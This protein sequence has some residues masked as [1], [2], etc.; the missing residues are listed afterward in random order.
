M[1]IWATSMFFSPHP[2]PNRIFFP[3]RVQLLE[4]VLEEDWK[5]PRF[6]SQI[7][8]LQFSTQLIAGT[9]FYWNHQ[10]LWLSALLLFFWV[11]EASH[12]YIYMYIYIDI[13]LIHI[14]PS[15]LKTFEC[16]TPGIYT[17]LYHTYRWFNLL[18]SEAVD[19]AISGTQ[20]W[21]FGGFVYKSPKGHENPLIWDNH[22]K[23]LQVWAFFGGEQIWCPKIDD[24]NVRENIQMELWDD[25][26][27]EMKKDTWNSKANH[28]LMDGNG[29][30]QAFFHGKRFGEPSSNW[31]VVILMTVDVSGSRCI[32]THE[33]PTCFC[34]RCEP[35]ENFSVKLPFSW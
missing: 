6:A 10:I 33:I 19:L 27:P 7:L 5:K 16:Q 21:L 35:C 15:L 8:A 25:W 14:H 9:D 20:T 11:G 12:K 26:S 18:T 29:D 23:C 17:H 32:S 28:V 4:M 2:I 34:W 13:F 1:L 31:N 24:Q 30:V 3:L 22:F